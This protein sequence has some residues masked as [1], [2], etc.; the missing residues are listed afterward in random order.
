MKI[1]QLYY[2]CVGAEEN[3]MAVASRVYSEAVQCAVQ[4]WI[5]LPDIVSSTHLPMLVVSW[6]AFDVDFCLHDVDIPKIG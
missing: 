2:L 4:E 6:V 1:F 5:S 3:S